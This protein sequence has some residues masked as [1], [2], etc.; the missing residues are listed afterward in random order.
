MNK[1][2]MLCVVLSIIYFICSICIVVFAKSIN[3][4]DNKEVIEEF[5]QKEEIISSNNH[6]HITEEDISIT[7][8]RQNE[9][10]EQLKLLD[11][12]CTIS[13]EEWFK[14]YKSLTEKYSDVSNELKIYENYSSEE[15]DLLF[16]VVQAEIGSEYSFEQK[17]NV[18][19]VIYNRIYDNRFGNTIKDILVK[20]QFSVINN[21]RINNVVVDENTVL[22]CEYVFEFGDTTGGALFFDS[23]GKLKYEFLFNDGA[24]NF[25][26]KYN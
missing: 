23:N 25:Y 24:H 1:K 8:I 19:S 18:V 9:F 26:K 4:C 20:G 2:Q 21:G 7:T 3:Y 16:R 5:E 15:L 10:E 13:R 6:E 14:Q 12:S 11:C 22:A 17:C